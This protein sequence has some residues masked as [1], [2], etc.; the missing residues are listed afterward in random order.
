MRSQP[1]LETFRFSVPPC[2]C[3][4]SIFFASPFPT[5]PSACRATFFISVGSAISDSRSIAHHTPGALPATRPLST[6]SSSSKWVKPWRTSPGSRSQRAA[7]GAWDAASALVPGRRAPIRGGKL[8]HPAQ[9]P[10][11]RP[12]AQQ[13]GAVAADGPEDGAM[14]QRPCPLGRARREI[15][16]DAFGA[17]AAILGQ[18]T[19][20]A[21]RPADHADRG[22]QI[23]HRLGEIPGAF[24]RRQ[25]C[26]Q[27]PDLR[28]ASRQRILQ[29][30]EP[31]D[32]PLDIAVDGGRL[33][34]EGDGRDRRRRIGADAGQVSEAGFG[35]GKAPAQLARDEDRTAMQIAGPGVIAQSLPGMQH[36]VELGGGQAP[37]TSG[38]RARKLWK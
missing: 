4:A 38:Q 18:R 27:A 23:H 35:I 24:L 7:T 11:L 21:F 17:G 16:R 31:R 15:G 9:Q 1:R 30:E 5:A 32:H 37:A 10:L 2:L 20:H 22:A 14:A 33:A 6:T 25:G 29:G 13:H 3:G 19:E 12:A 28:L 26:G 36:L 34:V 8:H